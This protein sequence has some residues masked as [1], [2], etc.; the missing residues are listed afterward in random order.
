[1]ENHASI[2]GLSALM[3][4]TMQEMRHVIELARAEG[5]DAK[6]IIGGAV[7][8]QEYADEIHADGYA[9][10]AADA[11][12]LARRLL[13]IGREWEAPMEMNE[14]EAVREPEGPKEELWDDLPHD[15]HH[16]ELWEA[17]GTELAVRQLME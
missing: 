11:V 14:K 8:T 15:S 13:G 7:I 17:D 16:D 4:T 10:D 1:M 2:I 9:R 3:T 6:I 12:R 5:L